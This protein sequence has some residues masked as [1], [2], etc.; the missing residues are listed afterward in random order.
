MSKIAAIN[1][2]F[3]NMKAF[4]AHI[5]ED[6]GAIGFVGCVIRKDEASESILVPVNFEATR[7]QMAFAAA[8][9]LQRCLEGED[10]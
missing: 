8:M 1:G 6:E 2:R 3:E 9:W 10:K 5:A 4:L 7:Q